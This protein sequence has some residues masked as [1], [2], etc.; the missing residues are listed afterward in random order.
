[1][2]FVVHN[3][4]RMNAMYKAF[5]LKLKNTLVLTST[6]P[7]VI[8]P[9]NSDSDDVPVKVRENIFVERDNGDPSKSR[10]TT[11]PTPLTNA[12]K[13]KPVA[14]IAI[15]KGERFQPNVCNH[16]SRKRGQPE[17]A[18][19]TEDVEHVVIN[20][21]HSDQTITI[22]ANFTKTLKQKLCELLRSNKDISAWTPEDMTGIPRELAEHKFNI[23]P[24][25]FPVWQKTG[26][27][28]EVRQLQQRCQ[29][30][31]RQESLKQLSS[32]SGNIEIY[33]D[34]MVI[35]YKN[36]GG[37]ITH[38][39][40]TFDKLRKADM[41]LNPKKRTFEE[42]TYALRF[43]FRASNNEAEYEALVAGLEPAI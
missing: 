8:E 2:Q 33:V 39:I 36:E 42:I 1:M 15:I 30:W 28:N 10:A 21:A 43:N 16:I 41:K 18:D 7:P 32:L 40:E 24:R 31:L 9:W 17:R 27:N 38:I 23:H 11:G 25:T 12:V 22:A 6:D 4:D 5:T 13:E 14:G 26:Q 19:G 3:F 20:D 37:L 34:D 29:N 35:K